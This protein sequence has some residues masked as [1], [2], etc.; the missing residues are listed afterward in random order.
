MTGFMAPCWALLRG[1]A[2]DG[3]FIPRHGT[4][5]NSFQSVA[6]PSGLHAGAGLRRQRIR[7]VPREPR[8]RPLHVAFS[9]VV[10]VITSIVAAWPDWWGGHCCGPRLMTDVVPFLVYFVALNFRLPART[11]RTARIGISTALAV[12]AAIGIAIHGHGALQTAPSAWSAF[13]RN[14]DQNQDRL[15]DWSDPQSLR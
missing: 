2:A 11:S 4:A 10:V 9:A 3:A 14:V 8:Q 5:G 15:W 12:L 6:G 7:I 1:V 13:P